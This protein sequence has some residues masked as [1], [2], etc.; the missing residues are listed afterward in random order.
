MA[1]LRLAGANTLAEA[2]EVLADF[3][4]RFNQRFGVPASQP[5]SAYRPL[6]PEL[7]LCGVLCIKEQRKVARDNTVQY[8]GKTL[9]LFPGVDRPSYAGT[10]VE[11]EER[12]D[13]RIVVKCGE[14]VLTPQEAPPLAA[15]LRS[16]IASPLLFR[17][18]WTRY[19]KGQFV[20]QK[21][22]DH[23]RER[24]SGTSRYGAGEG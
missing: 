4:P 3:L 10:R 18:C 14:E 7:D 24:R 9:Q 6:D 2:N 13:G 16:H 17:T 19:Q 20:S 22:L 1:E 11:V 15:E 23:W 5:E 21:P 12:L 8:H